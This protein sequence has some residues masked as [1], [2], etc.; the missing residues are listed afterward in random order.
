MTCAGH[1]VHVM[2]SPDNSF[3]G[4]VLGKVSKYEYTVDI[5]KV[6]NVPPVELVT[7]VNI[8]T[9][10]CK[11]DGG[12]EP[13]VPNDCVVDDRDHGVSRGRPRRDPEVLRNCEPMGR[14]GTC[15]RPGFGKNLGNPA[16]PSRLREADVEN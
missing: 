5:V 1:R 8:E 4:N 11:R 9:I 10:S 12:V 3:G 7:K 6:E 13:R 2:Q 15:S 14:G 16:S